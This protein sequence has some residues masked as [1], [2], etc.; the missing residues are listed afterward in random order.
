MKLHYITTS[1]TL[2]SVFQ[3]VLG[4]TLVLPNDSESMKIADHVLEVDIKATR[5]IMANDLDCGANYAA[6]VSAS[7]KGGLP[8]GSLIHFGAFRNLETNHR[9]RIYI[10]KDHN[11]EEYASYVR[12]RAL[13]ASVSE[14]RINEFLKQCKP[15][16]FGKWIFFRADP[17]QPGKASRS[18][19]SNGLS[20]FHA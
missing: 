12:I 10:V 8:V 1:L 5:S 7:L 3:L 14:E 15:Q 16:F 18:P 19:I 2:L 20:R 6:T 4:A 17:I 11:G 13:S 9:Y